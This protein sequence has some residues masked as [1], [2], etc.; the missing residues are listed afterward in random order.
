MKVYISATLRNFFGKHHV[1]ETSAGDIRSA[2]KLLTDEYPDA[3]TVLF[4]KDEN[5]RSFVRI[6]VGSEDRTSTDM[7]YKKLSEEDDILILPAIAGGASSD[8]IINDARMKAQTLDDNEIKR[9]EKHL[10]LKEIS[11]KGQKRIKA[12]RVI[13]C[14]AGALGS[15][16]IQYLASA[17]V[18]AIKVVDENEVALEDLQNQVIHSS[19]DVKRPKVASA[20]D[21][22]RNINK[23]IE[24]EAENTRLDAQNIEQIFDGYDL[25]IDCT[26]NYKMRYLINDACAL[27]D[28]PLVFAAIYQY[29]GR[30]GIFNHNGGPCLRCLYPEPPESGLVPTCAEGGTISPL[31]GIIGSI[32]ANEALKLIIGIGDHLDG[33]LLTVDSL[34]LQSRILNIKKNSQCPLCGLSKTIL[35]VED[36]DYDDFCGLKESEDEV[37]V[38]GITPEEL[39]KRMDGGDPMTIIDVREPHE[40]AIMRFPNAIVIPIGQLARR[41]KELDPEVDTIFICRSGKRSILAINTL[42][43]A[44][45]EGK[46]YNLKGGFDAMKDLIL[47]HEGAWL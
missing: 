3:R 44:G 40:R 43:E 36:F 23:N 42:R 4:D 32:Q 16:V 26:D 8:S 31:P 10:L 46:M 12:A 6:Y 15:P 25:V 18:G 37:P 28:I 22:V 19:R 34:Y 30:V 33:K 27:L 24:F 1:I 13:V 47:S 5:L 39:T 29:E 9:F 45:Y 35:S 17:G 20:K 7:W 11:V 21:T 2:L 38:E 14:G 41:M